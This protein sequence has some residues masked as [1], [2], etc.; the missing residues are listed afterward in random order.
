MVCCGVSASYQVRSCPLAPANSILLTGESARSDAHK[1]FAVSLM[2]L[3]V[4][5]Q[6]SHFAPYVQR[7]FFSVFKAIHHSK[8]TLQ[9]AGV[10]LLGD[11]LNVWR[12]RALYPRIYSQIELGLSRGREETILGS[13]LA[14]DAFVSRIGS[15]VRET[16]YMASVCDIV[17]VYLEHRAT[18]IQL[19]V[20]ALIPTV[21]ATNPSAFAA[22]EY[23]GKSAKSP[24]QL[25]PSVV[26]FL[27]ASL[28]KDKLQFAALTCIGK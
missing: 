16:T 3:L 17:A 6:H 9:A 15:Y 25:F 23:L 22:H 28:Q 13:L 12:G 24:V 7:V 4:C 27:L 21:A 19:A 2:S 1:Q 10:T 18:S 20:L 8:M 26:D 5:Y 11:C 14:A